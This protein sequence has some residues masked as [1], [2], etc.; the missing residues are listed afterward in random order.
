MNYYY[1]F[2]EEISV[3]GHSDCR[4]YVLRHEVKNIKE[5]AERYAVRIG[6]KI[7]VKLR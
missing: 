1:E 4:Y 3:F 6:K 5:S 7:M 2:T